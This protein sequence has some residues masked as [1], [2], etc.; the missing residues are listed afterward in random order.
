MGATPY[1]ECLKGET[2]AQAVE[3]LGMRGFDVGLEMSVHLPD[4][5]R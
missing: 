1:G 5:G 3:K 2:I 4:S